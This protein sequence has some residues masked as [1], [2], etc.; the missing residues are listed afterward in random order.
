LNE[1]EFSIAD[2][3]EEELEEVRALADMVRSN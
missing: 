3:E 2:I 1:D